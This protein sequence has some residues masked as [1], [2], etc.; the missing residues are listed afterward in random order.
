[1]PLTSRKRGV[2]YSAATEDKSSIVSET[3]LLLTQG[4]VDLP[5]APL[6]ETE[7]RLLGRR[8]RQNSHGDFVDH[9]PRSHDGA[10]NANS[11]ALWL[12]SKRQ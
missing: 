1:M 3:L 11:G 10:A 7:L 5:D 8:P 9:G 12:A 4:P 2:S 6:L